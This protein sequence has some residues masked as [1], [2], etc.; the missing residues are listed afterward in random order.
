MCSLINVE[1]KEVRNMRRRNGVCVCV[2]RSQASLSTC[3][4]IDK[5]VLTRLTQKQRKEIL[6][7][8]WLNEIVSKKIKKLKIS[9]ELPEALHEFP[10]VGPPACYLILPDLSTSSSRFPISHAN[11]SLQVSFHAFWLYQIESEWDLT[12]L[13]CFWVLTLI[14]DPT[15]TLSPTCC[16]LTISSDELLAKRAM[17]P[18][19]YS[20]VS[21]KMYKCTALKRL[22][23]AII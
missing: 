5:D 23:R 14:R 3:I 12:K 22:S 1:S 7:Q 16:L 17:Y 21:L 18:Q 9:F 13:I 11:N 6:S 19:L 10:P 20:S 4:A 15:S 2:P 8:T